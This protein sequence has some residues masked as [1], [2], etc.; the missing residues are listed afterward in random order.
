LH[1]K[2]DEMHAYIVS[3]EDELKAPVPTSCS[4]CELHA[5]KN[6][7]FSHYVDRL[8]DENDEL[9]KIMGCLSGHEPQLR[10][11]IEAYKRYDGQAL[12]T[13]KIGK[14]SGEGGEKIGDI[15]A[16]SKTFHKN[17]YAPK[18]NP[19]RNQLDTTPDPPVFHPQTND[20]QKP[21]KLKG[22][23][24][25]EFLGRK[26]TNLVRR[27]QKRSQVSSPNPR[28]NQNPFGSIVGIVEEMVTRMSFASR[29]SVRRGWLRSGL[30]RIG[31]T[32]QMLYLS[33][34]CKCPG[35]RLLLEW[36]WLGE[37]ERWQVVLLAEHHHSNR[38]GGSVRPVL[39]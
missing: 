3:L 25:S 17:S 26:E 4:T 19:L 11:V 27:N 21:I 12:G 33:L 39:V 32:T 35:S 10:M 31:T 16:P 13:D 1:Q 14:C 7:Q 38:S 20:F 6:L 36:F 30:T 22:D 28:L 37:I 8:H 34:V 29:G 5:V 24:G 15:Q 23:L 18:P 2:I 9:R